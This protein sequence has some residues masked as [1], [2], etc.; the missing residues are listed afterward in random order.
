MGLDDSLCIGD[1]LMRVKSRPDGGVN[2]CPEIKPTAAAIGLLL[3]A[4]KERGEIGFDAFKHGDSFQRWIDV[5]CHIQIQYVDTGGYEQRRT[6]GLACR[7][8]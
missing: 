6:N 4:G 1:G 8:S 5:P 2:D 3:E 7:A